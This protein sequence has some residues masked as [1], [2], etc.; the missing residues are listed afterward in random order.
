MLDTPKGTRSS[1]RLS[2]T[3]Q[4]SSAARATRASACNQ[5]AMT[6]LDK[7]AQPAGTAEREARVGIADPRRAGERDGLRT[8]HAG[9]TARSTTVA[10]LYERRRN[11]A[12]WPDFG[13]H[14]PPLQLHLEFLNG[15]LT[16]QRPLARPFGGGPAGLGGRGN[17]GAAGS[18]NLA[19]GSPGFLWG[20]SP[21]I[22][23]ACALRR[24]HSG[25]RRGGSGPSSP[26]D[27]RAA[28]HA[29]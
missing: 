14:R 10:A 29:S 21:G 16:R 9:L 28:K 15:L 23:P 26:L 12:F 27:R 4:S 17:A 1:R 7:P 8:N 25:S 24:G 18:A 13:G 20:R 19:P 22:G 2:S 5:C 11:C 6:G 3:T